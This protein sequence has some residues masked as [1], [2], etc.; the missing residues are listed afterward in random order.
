M[1]VITIVRW[2]YSSNF[3]RTATLDLKA[4]TESQE[5][6]VS[7]VLSSYSSKNIVRTYTWKATNLFVLFKRPDHFFL[8]IAVLIVWSRLCESCYGSLR[9]FFQKML[10]NYTFATDRTAM[11]F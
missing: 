5:E 7:L 1:V 3:Q 8:V 6:V 4:G 11:F 10:K 2:V 9:F